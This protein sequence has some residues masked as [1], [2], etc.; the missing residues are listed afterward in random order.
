LKQNQLATIAVLLSLFVSPVAWADIGQFSAEISPAETVFPGRLEGL[1]YFGFYDDARALVGGLRYG[2][3]SYTDGSLKFGVADFDNAGPDDTGFILAGDFRYQI[4]ELRLQDALDLSVGG[5]FETVL[6]FDTTPFSLGGFVVGSRHINLRGGGKL[7]PY[8]RLVLRWD[9]IGD[10]DDLNPGLVT[11]VN[12]PVTSG[13][14]VSGELQF[15]N[16]VGFVM[17]ATFVF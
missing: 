6:G 10:H 8:G 14:S 7:W 16:D 5:L 12:W 2:L 15:D 11:G 1:A 4:M 9:H 17:G 13:T 3:G